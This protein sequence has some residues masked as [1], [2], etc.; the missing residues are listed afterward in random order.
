[1]SR[2]GR[3]QS[4]LDG[5][6]VAHLSDEDDVGVLAQHASERALEGGGVH[7]DFALVDRRAFI[8]V[9]ELDGILDRDDVLGR[10]VVHVVD[11]RRERR[12]L[13]RAG[14]TR[15][16][17][18][19]PLLFGEFPDDSRQRELFDRADSVR[20]RAAY[21][22]DHAALLE[23][24]DPVAGD[25][26]ELDVVGEKDLQ[27]TLGVLGR[28]HLGALIG[29]QRSLHA[30]QRARVDLHV[31]IRALLLDELVQRLLDVEHGLLIGTRRA[32]LELRQTSWT[33]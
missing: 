8:G 1:V 29:R 17:N 12:R 21:H 27:R 2:L 18:D 9:H 11:H 24:V 5:L 15:E 33:N 25:L 4:G 13:A 14:R 10:G 26:R 3:R 32:G 31:K 23:G 7:A 16:Q 19:A 30:V 22:R 20:D 28:Q 6:F